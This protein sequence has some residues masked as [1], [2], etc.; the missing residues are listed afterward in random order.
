MVTNKAQKS[1][2]GSG[3]GGSACG[4]LSF[5][6]RRGPSW[7]AGLVPRGQRPGSAKAAENRT[8]SLQVGFAPLPT[9]RSGPPGAPGGPQGAFAGPVEGWG[10]VRVENAL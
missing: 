3:Q 10:R 1:P 9:L 4:A 5:M 2:L 6:A 7:G 8:A